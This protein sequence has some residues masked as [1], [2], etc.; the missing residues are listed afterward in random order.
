MFTLTGV[1]IHKLIS[2]NINQAVTNWRHLRNE[3]N[4]RIYDAMIAS[5]ILF[6]AGKGSVGNLDA[7]TYALEISGGVDGWMAKNAFVI[8]LKAKD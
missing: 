5:E 4:P 7:V 6:L 2:E 3:I 1:E 8:T